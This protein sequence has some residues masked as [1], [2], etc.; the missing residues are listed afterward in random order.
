MFF[1]LLFFVIEYSYTVFCVLSLYHLRSA[2]VEV[3]IYMWHDLVGLHYQTLCSKAGTVLETRQTEEKVGRQHLRL[4]ID[5]IIDPLGPALLFNIIG[6]RRR[7]KGRGE[8][9]IPAAPILQ[10]RRPSWLQLT[11]YNID[12]IHLFETFIWRKSQIGQEWPLQRPSSCTRPRE[13]FRNSWY[14]SFE[15]SP[16]K[17]QKI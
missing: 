16:G 13:I 10:V 15:T 9:S 2:Q 12:S 1:C 8:V 11:S 5:N 6:V 3:E 7:W 4:R 17:L 14:R